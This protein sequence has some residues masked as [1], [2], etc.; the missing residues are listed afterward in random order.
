[1]KNTYSKLF[2]FIAIFSIF[3]IENSE[4]AFTKRAA[5]RS[6]QIGKSNFANFKQ[7]IKKPANFKANLEQLRSTHN[8]SS[9]FAYHVPGAFKDKNVVTIIKT[10][11]NY[12]D[13]QLFKAKS[14]DDVNR[15]VAEG[16]DVNSF[17]I[18][19]HSTS[20]L[21]IIM[22]AILEKRLD[23]VEA[24]ANNNADVNIRD[25]QNNTPLHYTIFHQNDIDIEI[26]KIL[27]AHG[28]NPNIQNM[29]KK[30]S[31]HEILNRLTFKETW[32]NILNALLA[33]PDLDI[34][35]KDENDQTPLD[36]VNRSLNSYLRYPNKDVTE[37]LEEAKKLIIDKSLRL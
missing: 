19:R 26:I 8:F 37:M 6:S 12:L 18:G 20:P 13:R 22:E 31:L 16:A 33:F 3:F 30:T 25:D 7:P 32:L 9:P 35:I 21:P 24:L 34:N 27:F 15:L 14:A 1:M 4:A 36:T 11:Q 29:F 23:V 10:R 5:T 2:L 28:A 17:H